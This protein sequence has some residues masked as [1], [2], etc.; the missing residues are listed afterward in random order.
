[1]VVAPPQVPVSARMRLDA[2]IM[3][4]ISP[5]PST[6]RDPELLFSFIGIPLLSVIDD[7]LIDDLHPEEGA[8][9]SPAQGTIN[10]PDHFTL[11]P[12]ASNI[13]CL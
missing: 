10:G 7:C 2:T 5:I 3:T 13:V 1:M 9:V 6:A 12:A 8:E 4:N 11:F